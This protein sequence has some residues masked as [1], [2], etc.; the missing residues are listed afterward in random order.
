MQA[1]PE[2]HKSVSGQQGRSHQQGHHCGRQHHHSAEFDQEPERGARR[3]DASDTE[4]Q[5]VLFRSEGAHRGGRQ[6]RHCPFRMQSGS[7]RGGGAYVA[8]FPHGNEK[9]AWDDGGYQGQGE[10]IRRAVLQRARHD[11]PQ[12]EVQKLSG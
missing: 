6:R 9:K 10:V 3:G 12:D 11:V 2:R 4:G 8:R 5:A 1:D 7:Q